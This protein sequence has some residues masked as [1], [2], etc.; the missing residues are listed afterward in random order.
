[1]LLPIAVNVVLSLIAVT[2]IVGGLAWAIRG[3]SPRPAIGILRGWARHNT[4]RHVS[5]TPA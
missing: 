2:A 3:A 4:P 5:R 1:V